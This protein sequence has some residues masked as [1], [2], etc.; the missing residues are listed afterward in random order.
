MRRFLSVLYLTILGVLALP[1]H[2]ASATEAPVP[3]AAVEDAILNALAERGIDVGDA[4]LDVATPIVDL[5][6][7]TGGHIVA[8]RIAYQPQSRRFS[9]ILAV[10]HGSTVVHQLAV[11]GRVH[12]MVSMPVLTRRLARNETI[13]A[14]DIRWLELRDRRVPSNA[15]MDAEALIGHASRRPLRPG[16]PVLASDVRRPVLVERGALVTM[17][18]EKGGLSLTARGRALEDG[19][20][21][22]AV[23]I[24]N[25]QSGQIVVGTVSRSGVV[26]V[27][28]TRPP[29]EDHPL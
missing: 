22:E 9:A 26:S 18:L 16:V 19:G 15:V 11:A 12:R 23:R 29:V 8:D 10:Y 2:P 17:V 24:S 7:P 25:L 21:G 28:G 27:G 4:V 5:T 20:E 1:T 13:S 3:A 6:A 14:D